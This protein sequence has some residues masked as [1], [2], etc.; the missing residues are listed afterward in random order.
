MYKFYQIVNGK[1]LF[2]KIKRYDKIYQ[3]Y[4]NIQ[5]ISMFLHAVYT[6]IN[7]ITV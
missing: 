5:T 2:T 6:F 7:F 3:P 4:T 1:T